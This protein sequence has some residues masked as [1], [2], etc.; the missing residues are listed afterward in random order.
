MRRQAIVIAI[1][2][3]SVSGCAFERTYDT[4]DQF[5]PTDER[6]V[7]PRDGRVVEEPDVEEPVVL[8]GVFRGVSDGSLSGDIGPARNLDNDAP[9]LSLYDDGWYTAIEA[10][11][12]R[13]G[14]AA[15]F[16][17]TASMPEE[18]FV[19]GTNETY[20]L[21]DYQEAHLTVLGCTGPAQGMYDEF[22]V[23][24][25]EVDVVVE[26]GEQPGEVQVQVQARWNSI[27]LNEVRVA[28]SKFTLSR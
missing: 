19:V 6:F 26:D 8:G 21:E 28:E 12:V 3:V 1:V 16:L 22:D 15:M 13:P 11:D 10:V 17:V 7:V 20:R 5:S 27:A 14:R 24:A 23:P 4:N 2:G 25:D 9:Y 18:I